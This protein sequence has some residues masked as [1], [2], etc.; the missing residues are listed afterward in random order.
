MLEGDEIGML[1]LLWDLTGCL[2]ITAGAMRQ[3]QSEF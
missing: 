3:Q 2:L 1:W